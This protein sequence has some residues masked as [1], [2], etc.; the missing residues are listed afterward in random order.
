MATTTAPLAIDRRTLML[1]AWAIVRRRM[2]KGAAFAGL[3]SQAL[4]SAWF[5][6]KMNARVAAKS[7]AARAAVEK[8]ADQSSASLVAQITA[9]QNK[10][11]LGHDG[12]ARLAE[13]KK[14][15]HTAKAREADKR[16]LIAAS[17]G[18]I[19][20]VT[21][22]KKD[23]TS[24]TM[25]VQPATLAKR[26]KGDAATDAAKRATAT[27]KATHPNLM[28]VWDVEAKAARSINL[29]TVT[30]IATGGHVHTF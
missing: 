24:R 6:A 17:A 16:E 10:D 28:P 14:A 5:S 15:L 11:T 18:R 4:S 19:S 12:M 9:L 1:E 26:V 22:I 29:A 23:G 3:L 21:F 30:R 2:A 25:K 13:L 27:R 8:L 20:A 7:A